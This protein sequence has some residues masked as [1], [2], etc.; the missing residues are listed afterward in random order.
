MLALVLPGLAACD[1]VGGG[2]PVV[3]LEQGEVRLADGASLHEVELTGV[4]PESGVTPPVVE[5]RPGDAVVFE[6]QDALTHSVAFAADSLQPAQLEFLQ[7]TAQLRSPP[8][9]T[10]GARWI[11]SLEGAP[12]GAYP[13]VCALHGGRGR[14]IVSA[15]GTS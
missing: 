15:N 8:L 7:S 4:V 1:A 2:A 11:I 12:S 9:L 3:E 14:I 5:A 10:E 13:F 6:A